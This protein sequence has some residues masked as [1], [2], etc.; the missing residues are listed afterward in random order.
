MFRQ[1]TAGG[2]PQLFAGEPRS[3]NHLAQHSTG[4]LDAIYMPDCE[5]GSETPIAGE[6]TI[7]ATIQVAT[8]RMAGWFAT[9]DRLVMEPKRPVVFRRICF[10]ECVSASLRRSES[11]SAAT[12]AHRSPI[13]ALRRYEGRRGTTRPP[14]Q[15]PLLR[16]SAMVSGVRS[17]FCEPKWLSMKLLS[18]DT[19]RS[20][21]WRLKAG[22]R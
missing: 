18:A 1:T 4:V 3:A 9:N 16:L 21:K 5:S 20:L 10:P 8:R 15:C 14:N 19:S 13:D 6:N 12:A 7:S 17:P 11:A 2:G 22:I